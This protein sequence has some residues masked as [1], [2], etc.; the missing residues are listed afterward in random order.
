MS[1]SSTCGPGCITSWSCGMSAAAAARLVM[2]L[3]LTH[4][5]STWRLFPSSF[6]QDMRMNGLCTSYTHLPN[7]VFG[8]ATKM[9]GS[10]TKRVLSTMSVTR[11]DVL[12]LRAPAPPPA[13]SLAFSLLKPP[14]VV[15]RP[16]EPLGATLWGRGLPGREEGPPSR[17]GGEHE[18]GGRMIH[19][20]GAVLRANTNTLDGDREGGPS[21]RPG[22]PRPHRVAPSGSGGLSTTEGGFKSLVAV[23]EMVYVY[24]NAKEAAGGGAGARSTRT[25]ERVTLI[26]DNTRFVVDPTIFVAQP[27]TML[28]SWLSLSCDES[29]ERSLER[30]WSRARSAP[31]TAPCEFILR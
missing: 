24:E 4:W 26:V 28:G 12:V 8:C 2:D 5:K 20:T 1:S 23:G 29:R 27:N 13:A 31:P 14:S 22:S 16:P 11:S 3:D 19:L 9:V 25:S 15:D 6:S 7:M 18:T 10:T 17:S 30:R 21:S